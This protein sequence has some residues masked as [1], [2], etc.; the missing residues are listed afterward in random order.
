VKSLEGR[1]GITAINGESPGFDEIA[2]NTGSIDLKTKE[3]I[4]DV[5]P[6]V[7]DAKFRHAL[8]YALNLDQLNKQVYQ[9]A[10]SAGDS[11]IPPTYS[12]YRW[13]PS[14]DEAFTYEPEKAKALL[15][16]AGYKLGTDGFRTLPTGDPIGKLRLFGRADSE[17][18]P[19][20]MQFFQEW[21]K[22][23]GID[24]DLQIVEES[25]LTDI[26]L[27]GTFDAFEWGWYVEPNPDSMLSYFTCD[28]LGGWSDSW[29][30]NAEYDA[31]Y[32]AQHAETDQAI[33]VD[34]IKQMQQMI[35]RDSPY[36][37]TSYNTIGEAY[38][39]DRFACLRPQPDPGGV[40][41]F[42]YGAYNYTHMRPAA[43]AGD[44]GGQVGAS[45]A[46]ATKGKDGGVGAGALVG[47]GLGVLALLGLGG[48]VLTRKRATVEDRE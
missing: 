3:P 40:L 15:D 7:Q 17:S 22:D 30:C 16:D 37:V 34:T 44:C 10:G 45:G 39:S 47:V 23:I 2:F 13:E 24:S 1:D 18:S 33:R 20:V 11:F 48:F 42:Q 38:R 43:D 25:K 4:G 27:E 46:N 6:A 8:G 19:K 32:N 9:G 29:Y 26:V 14:V 41:I 35:F 36:L 28:Q 5:N 21:L 31:L 12:N